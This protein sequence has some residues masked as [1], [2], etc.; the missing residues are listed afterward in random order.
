M[1]VTD[2]ITPAN[3]QAQLLLWPARSQQPL[4]AASVAT[5]WLFV[6]KPDS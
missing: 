6:T 3:M 4:L 1:Q 5:A 2:G